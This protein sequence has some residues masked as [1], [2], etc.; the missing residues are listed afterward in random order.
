M[1][2]IQ[3]RQIISCGG[4]FVS[5]EAVENECELVKMVR[6]DSVVVKLE[7]HKLRR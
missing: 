7:E 1:V 2:D 3:F 4:L 6:W 5:A